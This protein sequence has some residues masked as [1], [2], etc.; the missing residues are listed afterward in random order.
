MKFQKRKHL[1]E[2]HKTDKSF[3]N[4]VETVVQVLIKRSCQIYFW[5]MNLLIYKF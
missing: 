5:S 1:E 3:E 2:T 4:N